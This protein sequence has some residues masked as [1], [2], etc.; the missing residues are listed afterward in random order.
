MILQKRFKGVAFAISMH[1]NWYPRL[2]IGYMTLWHLKSRYGNL[3]VTRDP[4]KFNLLV[5]WTSDDFKK[6]MSQETQQT[7]ERLNIR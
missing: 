1:R 7:G 4:K 6:N 2:C 5:W 3:E